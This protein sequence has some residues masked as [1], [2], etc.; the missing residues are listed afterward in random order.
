MVVEK[1]LPAVKEM[2]LVQRRGRAN[3]LRTVGRYGRTAL[4]YYAAHRAGR[5]AALAA[6]RNRMMT[7]RR[8]QVKSG[9]G[10][11]TQ[12]DRRQIYSKKSMP[13]K[14]KRIWRKF[15]KKVHAVAE[16]ELGTRTVLFNST[17]TT[18]S[19]TVGQQG[20]VSFA[21]Y[22]LRSA[23]GQLND[24]F[25]IS[26]LE[27]TGDPTSAGGGNVDDTTMYMFQS[28]IL[29]LTI[30][31]VSDLQTGAAV[32]TQTG[33]AKIELDIYEVSVRKNARDATGNFN[34]LVSLIQDGEIA[35]TI[36]VG[37]GLTYNQRGT[38]PW[39]FPVA[40]SKFG[41][42][43][44]KKTKFFIPNNDTITYQ[45][46][47][48]KRHTVQRRSLTQSEGCNMPGMT[49]FI[50]IQFKLVPGLTVGS[51]VGEYRQRI[52]TGVTRKYMYKIEGFNDTRDSFIAA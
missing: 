33:E 44:W 37:T 26:G 4:S 43:I 47:D 29:D 20:L 46:R 12:Y 30:R 31:N 15:V 28:G 42:K 45:M 13:R 9:Q 22:P 25:A 49:R 23:S 40:L 24:L 38:T 36:A 3:F 52:V 35:K 18:T 21:L 5:M 19:N 1:L 32:F 11:T 48:P 17:Y 6:G 10:V 51:A 41:I 39:D 16:K 50:L 34:S 14:K 8:N 7:R 27:N 2:A